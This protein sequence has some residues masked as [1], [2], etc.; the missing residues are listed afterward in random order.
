MIGTNG[1]GF[2]NA[3][4]AHPFENPTPLTNFLQ[5]LMIFAIPSGLTYTLGRMTGSRDT[6]G[7]CGARWPRCFSPAS[8][9]R[10]AAESRGN[11]LLKGV[12]QSGTLFH[13]GGN[14]EGK[15]VRFGIADSALFTTV[16]T[17]ASCGAVNNVHDSLHAT[18]RH[19]AS[20]QH[21]ARRNYFRRRGRGALRHGGL[22]R[23]GRVH[24][25]L[26][27]WA[28]AGISWKEN[29]SVRREDG[30]AFHS[31]FI[32]HHP[33]FFR[34]RDCQQSGARRHHQSRPAWTF[35][36]SL[37][38]HFGEPATTAP[39]SAG[40]TRTRSGTTPRI[41]HRH[42]AGA[43]FRG[44]SHPGHRW[45]PGAQKNTCPNRWE[46]FPSLARSSPCCSSP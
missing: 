32:A 4:S 11:P 19:G 20:G 28:H 46:P 16:T 23:A 39:R 18:R 45:K 7:P 26:D 37:C 36:D 5:M 40:S 9:W 25:R 15:E 10:T 27:G 35:A 8:S 3:N 33:D 38:L 1:G 12:D 13:S 31:G 2:F 14:M 44:D 42:A 22:R 6:D 24:R 41:A 43:I 17:D 29:R 34:D 21:H 30:G